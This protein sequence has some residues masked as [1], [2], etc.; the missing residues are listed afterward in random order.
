MYLHFLRNY[1]LIQIN[2][3]LTDIRGAAKIGEKT[4][5]PVQIKFKR[6]F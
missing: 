3:K 1:N 5:E 4:H 6:C 2:Q